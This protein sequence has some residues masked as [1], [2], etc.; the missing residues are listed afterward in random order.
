[1]G[2][3]DL[4]AKTREFVNVT[5]L[6]GALGAEL[7]LRQTEQE[8]DPQVRDAMNAVLKNLEPGLL[9]VLEPGHVATVIGHLTSAL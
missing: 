7:R 6:M 4:L 5:Q 9:D 1:M 8:G 2:Y 3:P